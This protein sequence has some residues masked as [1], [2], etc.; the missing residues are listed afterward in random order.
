MFRVHQLQHFIS[1]GFHLF[2]DGMLRPQ[3]EARVVTRQDHTAAGGALGARLDH[4]VGHNGDQ[5]AHVV[6]VPVGASKDLHHRAKSPH[7]MVVA[8]HCSDQGRLAR[9]VWANDG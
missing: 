1:A 6:D 2:G 8:H 9:T 5:L 4:F 3:L 7:R